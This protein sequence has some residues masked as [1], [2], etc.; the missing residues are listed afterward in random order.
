MTNFDIDNIGQVQA[1]MPPETLSGMVRVRMDL[2]G[3]LL[4]LIAVPPQL[5]KAAAPAPAPNPAPLFT[6]ADLDFNSFR[7]AN[8]LWAAPVASDLRLAW[9]APF[10]GSPGHELRVE[11]AWWNGKPVWF[12]VVTPWAVPHRMPAPQT[13]S[14]SIATIWSVSRRILFLIAVCALSWRNL[15]LGRGDRSGAWRLASFIFLLCLADTLLGAHDLFSRHG[16]GI[17]DTATAASLY[18]AARLWLVYI[19]IE[20]AV[21]RRWPRILIS[22][23]RIATGKW[24]DPMVGRDIL[25][26]ILA[27]LGYTVVDIGVERLEILRGGPP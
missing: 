21:R 20:P 4:S 9:T 10:P 27:G 3:H 7:P 18:R 16:L 12:H 13:T 14:Y 1:T 5:D 19:A 6:A 23:S 24:K 15:R 26:G 17:L 2:A 11:T 22:W 8:P 25:A